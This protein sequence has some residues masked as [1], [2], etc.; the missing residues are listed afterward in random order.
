MKLMSENE[1]R[2]LVRDYLNGDYSQEEIM[3]KFDLVQCDVCGQ[4]ELEED[5]VNHKWDN[6]GEE[7]KICPDCREDE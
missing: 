4:V 7:D 1:A 6:A 5:M 3:N 2:E